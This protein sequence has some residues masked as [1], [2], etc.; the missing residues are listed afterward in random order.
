MSV[1]D[2]I[3][4]NAVDLKRKGLKPKTIYIGHNDYRELRESIFASPYIVHSTDDGGE[5]YMGLQVIHVNVPYYL[6]VEGD[7]DET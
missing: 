2:R 7:Y 4:K 1:T 5:S 6:K 3:I